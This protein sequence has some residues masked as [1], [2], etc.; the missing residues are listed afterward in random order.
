MRFQ[1]TSV[2]NRDD[3]AADTDDGRTTAV[4]RVNIL[5]CIIINI[6]FYVNRTRMQTNCDRA[7]ARVRRR[8]LKI[9]YFIIVIILII[10]F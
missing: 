9:Y 7:A 6:L 4:T 5:L 2:L 10:L 8:A 3:R 1:F